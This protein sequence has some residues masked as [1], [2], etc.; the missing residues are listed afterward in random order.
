MGIYI[1]QF[2]VN[3]Y[4]SIWICRMF[5][6]ISNLDT[7]CQSRFTHFLLLFYYCLLKFGVIVTIQIAKDQKM[8]HCVCEAKFHNKDPMLSFFVKNF[9]DFERFNFSIF[10]LHIL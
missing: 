10:C 2:L 7:N 9:P 5:N 6:Y 4:P 1:N 3:K 8:N